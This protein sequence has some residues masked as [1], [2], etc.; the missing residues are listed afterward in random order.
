MTLRAMFAAASTV[1]SSRIVR[2][3][4]ARAAREDEDPG[5]RGVVHVC[6]RPSD[7]MKSIAASRVVTWTRDGHGLTRHGVFSRAHRPLR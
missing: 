6:D 5:G 7:G 3:V 4:F 1:T 2:P